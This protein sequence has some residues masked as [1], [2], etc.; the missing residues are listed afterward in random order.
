[1]RTPAGEEQ[2]YLRD[3]AAPGTAYDN[4]ALG[5][6][7]QPDHMDGFVTMAANNEGVHINLGILNRAAYLVAEGGEHHGAV[8]EHGIGRERLA[9]LYLASIRSLPAES[10]VTF[11]AFQELVMYA[12]QQQLADE[13][14]AVV[15]AA[16]AAV[17]L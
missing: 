11:A 13:D 16:F 1:V 7:S 3:L 4:S 9:G 17:G 15:H 8:V 6:D 10:F 14:V 5:S 12:A 2:Q